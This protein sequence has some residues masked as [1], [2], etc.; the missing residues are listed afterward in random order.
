M[1]KEQSNIR[2]I[3]YVGYST[4]HEGIHELPFKTYEE[5]HKY[6]QHCLSLGDPRIQ[7]VHVI[8]IELPGEL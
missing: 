1:T 2:Y 5:A 7:N 4:G 3:V 8:P 6:R